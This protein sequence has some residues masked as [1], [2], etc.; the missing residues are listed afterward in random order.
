MQA[1]VLGQRTVCSE[2][3]AGAAFFPIRQSALYGS[4]RL[5][6]RIHRIG[7]GQNPC[8]FGCGKRIELGLASLPICSV[9]GIPRFGRR[10][11]IRVLLSPGNFGIRRGLG[12]PVRAHA[13]S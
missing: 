13:L 6:A 3:A 11:G 9:S 5:L 7:A 10:F 2:G 8:P 12:G 1:G 4:H